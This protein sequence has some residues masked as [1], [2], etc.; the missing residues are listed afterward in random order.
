MSCNL[1][2]K[3]FCGGIGEGVM[4]NI[5]ENDWYTITNSSDY[6]VYV[7]L[8]KNKTEAIKVG[9]GLLMKS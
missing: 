6:P 1:V 9:T 2:N 5:N 8:K 3:I 7:W 4:F